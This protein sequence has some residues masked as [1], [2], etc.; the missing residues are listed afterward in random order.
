MLVLGVV[1]VA[2]D[3]VGMEKEEIVVGWLVVDGIDVL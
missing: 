2:C 1:L 3:G